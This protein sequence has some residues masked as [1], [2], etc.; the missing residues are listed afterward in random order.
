[1]RLHVL[2]EHSADQR[3]HGGSYI[4]LL[5][6][7][8]HP[9][10]AGAWTLTH[11]HDYAGGAEAVIVERTWRPGAGGLRAAEALVARVRAEGSRLI[12]ALDDNLLDWTPRAIGPPGPTPEQLSVVRLLARE[13]DGIMASTP[14]LAERLR[15]LNAH[16][17][18]VP[19]A[20]DE[21]LLAPP[22]P[23]D[24]RSRRL[25]IGY[26]GTYSHDA[27]LGLVLGALRSVL[28]AHAERLEFQLIGGWAGRAWRRAFDGLPMR[29]LDAERPVEYPQF[30]TWFTGQVRWDIGLGP[31][32]DT[33]FTRCKSDIKFLDYAA[34]GAAG[35]FS[36]TVPYQDS[37]VNGETG[38]LVDDDPADWR[39]ALERL[40]VE[41]DLRRRL[42]DNAHRYLMTERV[43]AVCAGQWRQAIQ[44]IMGGG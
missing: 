10:Q 40:I 24:G 27:D 11:G 13:A 35:I 23:A 2:F 4:R 19:N 34:I 1:M 3:P 42:A 20:L 43:L 36:R 15:R 44:A 25:V 41:S 18:V 7:L 31:L 39:E 17:R 33:A 37:V 12:Y 5:R 21:R 6:P 9:A 16:V 26:M 8:S 14:A 29:I 22:R 32:E 38:L 28:R 30:M